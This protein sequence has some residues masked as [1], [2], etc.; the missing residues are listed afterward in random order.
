MVTVQDLSKLEGRAQ[1]NVPVL[2]VRGPSNTQISG[3]VQHKR[4]QV[5]PPVF[6]WVSIRGKTVRKKMD[7]ASKNA[8]GHG[9]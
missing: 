9:G 3:K 2:P 5:T 4:T 1:P 7:Q 6:H 8:L